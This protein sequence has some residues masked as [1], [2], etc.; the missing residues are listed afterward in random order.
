MSTHTCTTKYE[1][2]HIEVIIADNIM[3]WFFLV[4]ILSV[5]EDGVYISCRQD[6]MGTRYPSAARLF[7]IPGLTQL[8]FENQQVS[9]NPKY[10]VLPDVLGIPNISGEP[11]ISGIP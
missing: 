6:P 8:S 10:R 7:S 2:T 3:C 4:L 11:E 5:F 1:L 9:S